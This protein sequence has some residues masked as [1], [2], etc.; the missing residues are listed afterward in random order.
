MKCKSILISAEIDQILLNTN[1]RDAVIAFRAAYPNAVITTV[2]N[3]PVVGF[4]AICDEPLFEDS[5]YKYDAES[6][7]RWCCGC[8]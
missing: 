6:G 3:E 5:D 7:I 1:R 2:D 4:C 8:D